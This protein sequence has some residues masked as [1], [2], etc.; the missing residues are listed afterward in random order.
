MQ[1]KEETTII[2]FGNYWIGTDRSTSLQEYLRGHEQSTL[3]EIFTLLYDGDGLDICLDNTQ[4]DYQ[5]EWKTPE[6]LTFLVMTGYLTYRH[7]EV[8]IPNTEVR[9]HWNKQIRPLFNAAVNEMYGNQVRALFAPQGEFNHQDCLDFMQDIL[10]NASSQDLA[11]LQYPEAPY[12]CFY[13]GIFLGCL[14][15]GSLVKVTSNKEAA[16]GRYDIRIQ[17]VKFRRA[18]IFE[19]KVDRSVNNTEQDPNLA[20]QQIHNR[21]YYH[22][23]H[24]YSVHLIGVAFHKKHVVLSHELINVINATIFSDS[25]VLLL[26]TPTYMPENGTLYEEIGGAE[27]VS[28]VVDYFY[29]LLIK[30]KRVKKYFESIDLDRLKIMQ[31]SFISSVCGGPAYNG[32]SMRSAHKRLLDLE[33][34]HFDAILENLETAMK[35]AAK[36]T[37]S[38]ENRKKILAVAETTRKDVLGK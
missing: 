23:L 17:F 14:H 26:A 21:Q 19:F 11:R 8:I 36:K 33:N 6:I 18:F 38:E 34:K 3:L 25:D 1:V 37:I 7:N 35:K 32:Q 30:D 28:A 2:K 27:T 12:H 5:D 20:L 9:N 24:G 29:S 10:L 16:L 15:D 13:F 31:K 4:V 22:D